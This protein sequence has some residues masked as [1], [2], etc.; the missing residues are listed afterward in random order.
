MMASDRESPSPLC[1]ASAC[2]R[3]RFCAGDRKLALSSGLVA[4]RAMADSPEDAVTFGPLAHARGS[5]LETGNSRLHLVWW[6]AG[7]WRT[8]LRSRLRKLRSRP[9]EYSLA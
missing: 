8:P 3:A 5:V 6:P 2:S 7:P 1:E 9:R 4:R